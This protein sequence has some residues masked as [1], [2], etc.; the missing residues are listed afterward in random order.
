MQNDKTI[1]K[2]NALT[3]LDLEA[4]QYQ[5]ERCIECKK[6]IKYGAMAKTRRGYLCYDCHFEE[7][8]K[9]EEHTICSP[10]NLK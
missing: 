7:W 2:I 4:S 10:K 1:K 9:L 5:P 3:W 8:G 6:E